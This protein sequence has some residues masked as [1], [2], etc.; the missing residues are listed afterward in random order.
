VV[1]EEP[2]SLLPGVGSRTSERLS[3]IEIETVAQLATADVAAL[4]RA[5]GPKHGRGLRA[6]ANGK[7]SATLT[8]ERQRKSESRETTFPDDVT[9]RELLKETIDR[10]GR[11][12]CRSLASHGARG[13][14]VTLKIR[15]RPFRTY[16][17]SRTL[18]AATCDED[19]VVDTAQELLDRFDPQAPVRLVGVGVANLAS[20]GGDPARAR[21]ASAEGDDA[22]GRLS[23]DVDAA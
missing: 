3:E 17:R 22:A 20:D 7:G 8:L 19:V 21:A 16:T 5:F 11:S 6:R 18:E 2:A 12:V 10:L 15:L 9:D 14:T 13:R 4:D 23:L 1:G